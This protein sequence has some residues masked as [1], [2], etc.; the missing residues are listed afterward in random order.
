MPQT[1]ITKVQGEYARG[2]V[3]EDGKHFRHERQEMDPVLKHVRFLDEKVN[4]APKSGNSNDM[5]YLGSIPLTILIDWE[6]QQGIT[7]DQ[8]ARDE[9]GVKAKFI[10][11]LRAEHPMFMARK[12]K[13]S[14]IL[15]PR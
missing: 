3:S 10:A 15:L 4:D 11:Y 14:Q 13:S 12:K 1:K 7:H 2:V 9:N 6:N 8:W 5:H